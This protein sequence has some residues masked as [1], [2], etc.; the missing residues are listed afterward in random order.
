M[1][2][3]RPRARVRAT[4]ALVVAALLCAAA[5]AVAPHA[6]AAPPSA[7]VVP[8]EATPPIAP[9][10]GDESTTWSVRPADADGADGRSWAELTLDAGESAVE[11]MEVRNLGSTDAVF[12]LQAADG[13]FTETGRFNM[14][15]RSE[16]STGAGTWID[17]PDEI[18]VPAGGSAIVPFTIRVPGNATPGDHPA[19]VAAGVLSRGSDAGGNAVGVES[20]IGFRVMVRVTGELTPAVAVTASGSYQGSA[21]PIDPGRVSVEYTIRND[22]NA[23]LQVAPT[24]VASPLLGDAV[25]AAGEPIADIAPGET[26]TGTIVLR[27]VWPTGVV[28]VAVTATAAT[29]PESDAAVAP[30]SAEIP[31]TAIPWP[32]LAVLLGAATLIMLLVLSRRSRRRRLDE[33]LAA[34]R[35]EGRRAASAGDA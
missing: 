35:E 11:H 22:G 6:I 1:T 13:Y 24:A 33:M 26:R 28:N 2:A 27:G 3:G 18:R 20:R 9:G 15:P 10:A 5:I 32:Q 25:E 34:A 19:G 23:R 12:G 14:L 30:V 8:A 31:V 4:T 16:E 29:V 17:I 21:S 7:A